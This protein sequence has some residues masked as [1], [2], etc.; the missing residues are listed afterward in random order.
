VKAPYAAKK[1]V[2]AARRTASFAADLGL[3]VVSALL[4]AM[5]GYAAAR[6]GR[7]AAIGALSGAALPLAWRAVVTRDMATR[8]GTGAAALAAFSVGVYLSYTR[9]VVGSSAV[10]TPPPPTTTDA[11]APPP[12]TTSP[13]M[14]G[15]GAPRAW[16]DGRVRRDVARQ[17]LYAGGAR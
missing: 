6:D 11:G 1:K 17:P 3:V 14:A 5:T 16:P 9:P 8:L 12:G 4:S 7:G 10:A 15:L 13:A 2:A